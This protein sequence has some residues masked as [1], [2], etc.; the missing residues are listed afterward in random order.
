MSIIH[1]CTHALRDA[2]GRQIRTSRGLMAT[3]ALSDEAAAYLA[4]ALF[5]IYDTT[6]PAATPATPAWAQGG[7]V[8]SVAHALAVK[9]STQK[10]FAVDPGESKALRDVIMNNP[11]YKDLKAN[12][13]QS[14][15]N[16]GVKL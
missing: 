15:S 10:G 11:T 7:G 8:Y 12:P 16:N 14:Y 5:H 2:A 6:A 4:G 3:L 9:M 13:K 1:E